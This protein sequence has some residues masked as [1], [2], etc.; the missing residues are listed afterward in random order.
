MSLRN[1][2][3]PARRHCV[4][5]NC[6][7]A[8]CRHQSKILLDNFWI[9]ALVAILVETECS[10]GDAANIQLF[11]TG[12]DEFACTDGRTPVLIDTGM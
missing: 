11:I 3:Q 2:Q 4:G 7:Q 9:V 8:V 12:K 1:I 10:I 5:A 6:V